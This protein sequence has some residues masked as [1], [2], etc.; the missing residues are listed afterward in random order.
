MIKIKGMILATTLLAAATAATAQQTYR[1][2]IETASLNRG[3]YGLRSMQDG[4]H[5]TVRE[6]NA[7][8]RHSYADASQQNTLYTGT[9]SSYTLSPDETTLLLS[10]NHR[11]VY[12]HSFYADWQIVPLEGDGTAAMTLEGVRDVTL[13]PDGRMVA[14]A[15]DNNLYIAPVGGEARAVTDDGE[16]NAVING[17]ADWVY[18]EEYGFTRAYAFSPDSKRIA[19]LRFDESAV[20]TFEMM[21]YDGTLYNRPYSFKYPKAGDRN[22]TVELWLYDIATGAKSRIDTGAETD[23]YLPRIDWTPAG[24]L[25]YYRVNRKQNHFEVVLVHNDGTQKVIYDETSP[26]FVERPDAGTI[27]FIDGERFIALNETATGWNHI[28]LYSTEKG[29]LN[30]VTSGPW[31]VTS[32]VETTDK[33]IYYI[34]TETSPLRR[35]LYSIDYKG[36]HKKRLTEGEGTYSIAP[37]RGMKYYISTFSTATEP[38]TVTL[39]KGDGTLLRTLATSDELAERMK[40]MPR[41]EFF[42]FVTER[43]DSLNAYMIKPVDFDPSKRYPV[44]VTQYSGPGSQ[45]VAD[46]FSL[47]WENVIAAHGYIIAC[48]DGRGTGYMGEKFKKQTYG[49]LGALEVEDQIS[50]ARYLG[51]Q[52]YVD[53]GRIGIYGWSYGGFMA[54][55]CACKGGGIYKL[56]IAVAPVTSWRYYD[57]IYTEI[58]NDLPQDNPAGYDDNSPINFAQLLDDEHTQLLIMHGTADDNVHFQNT[59]EMCRALNRA[60]KQYDMMIYPD[61]NHSMYP[62][63]GYNIRRKMVEYTLRNL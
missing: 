51:E 17:T 34:S 48:C 61:Q 37:S 56:A 7:I 52:P 29:L 39:H 26:T 38:N 49:N 6:G 4:E 57:T 19:Y 50:F 32:V 33:A 23:Q 46:R 41:K 45:S 3:V 53:A 21:R 35:N 5:Y 11:P 47:D 24:E 58:Y 43:G 12:R 22:S 55:G 31:Q 54:L 44:L 62:S 9:F 25:F 8:V 36:R 18:E 27:R 40:Q 14:Y 15:K 30:P 28:Y 42:T 60:G 10:S 63:D 1:E 2:L 20:P 13:S 16:W 59:M